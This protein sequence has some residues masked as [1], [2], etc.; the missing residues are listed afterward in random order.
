MERGGRRSYFEGKVKMYKTISVIIPTLNAESFVKR[1]IESLISQSMK[2]DEIIIVDSESEDK[3][4]EIAKSF[5]I[6]KVIQIKRS[7]FNHGGTRDMALK[8]SCGEYV[9]FM[10]QDAIPANNYMIENL[11]RHIKS[12]DK[13]AV[14]SGRQ[15]ARENSSYAERLIR[16]FNYVCAM[17]DRKIYMTLGG[18]EQSLVTNEDMFFAAK[19]VNYDYKIGYASDAE[20]IHSHDFTLKEQYRRNYLQGYEIERHKEILHFKTLNNSG[21]SLAK[22]VSLELLKRGKI[23]LFIKFGMDCIARLLGNR[24]GRKLLSMNAEEQK[25]F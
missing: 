20:V 19:A 13:I 11:L 5:Q 6:V 18:F 4:V 9:V 14:V 8:L 15:I 23:L 22:N 3:T 10:T 1:L 24:G 2:P 7:E 12:E 21:F 17:Y 25:R 16:E